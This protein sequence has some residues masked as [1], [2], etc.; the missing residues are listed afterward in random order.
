M[1]LSVSLAGTEATHAECYH[2]VRNGE[3]SGGGRQSVA[4]P[5][6]HDKSAHDDPAFAMGSVTT[7]HGLLVRR[8]LTHPVAPSRAAT[9]QRD[10]HVPLACGVRFVVKGDRNN[11]RAV[12]TVV[13]VSDEATRFMN[14]A[15]GEQYHVVILP[16][17]SA[18]AMRHAAANLDAR[19][20]NNCHLVRVLPMGVFVPS[21]FSCPFAESA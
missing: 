10:E 5:W 7:V 6:R 9:E 14:G 4:A 20:L 15:H 18:D 17:A 1:C 11:P 21:R 2:V 16:L 8:R 13:A 19:G 3:S 12:A